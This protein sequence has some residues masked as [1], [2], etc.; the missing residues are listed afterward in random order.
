MTN[1]TSLIE[2]SGGAGTEKRNTQKES[3]GDDDR[4]GE[5]V[6]S[7]LDG[8]HLEL[9][10]ALLS[11]IT[12]KSPVNKRDEIGK[13]CVR[14]YIRKNNTLEKKEKTA[15]CCVEHLLQVNGGNYD[16]LAAKLERVSGWCEVV[17]GRATSQ[18]GSWTKAAEFIHG[19]G[20]VGKDT[21]LIR[22]NLAY[23]G[24]ERDT[25]SSGEDSWMCLYSMWGIIRHMN[26]KKKDFQGTAMSDAKEFAV[27]YLHKLVEKIAVDRTKS[28]S[29]HFMMIYGNELVRG[30]GLEGL[31]DDFRS[32]VS[33]RMD[34]WAEKNGHAKKKWWYYYNNKL[35][36]TILVCCPF[37]GKSKH[38]HARTLH[39][40]QFV[41][42]FGNDL[43]VAARPKLV[44]LR[45]DLVQL[46]MK[47]FTYG[48]LEGRWYPNNFNSVD[49]TDHLLKYIGTTGG[50]LKGLCS[51]M[52]HSDSK[53][54]IPVLH[55]ASTKEGIEDMKRT[56]VC[57]RYLQ[58]LFETAIE[59]DGRYN[60]MTGEIEGSED[61]VQ[62]LDKEWEAKVAKDGGAPDYAWIT[63]NFG[64]RS[65]DKYTCDI[66][67]LFTKANHT[68]QSMHVDYLRRKWQK[69]NWISFMPISE[70]GMYV[71]I[72]GGRPTKECVVGEGNTDNRQ[73]GSVIFI[74]C[75]MTLIV[76]GDTVHG[77]GMHCD[78]YKNLYGNPRL[79]IYIKTSNGH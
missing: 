63:E 14:L 24:Q 40:R 68:T 65:D 64:N 44:K 42:S 17:Q 69:D 61:Y 11:T 41:N 36:H 43:T 21:K 52:P 78:S 62:A 73:E 57:D 8:N 13:H 15:C 79:H 18:R 22:I 30:R 55:Y 33:Q 75:G 48:V 71:Q 5:A 1:G 4:D 34:T 70:T 38:V 66:G 76:H 26:W 10:N 12:I 60:E 35:L 50:L 67:Y 3:D 53:R 77:G 47:W 37:G 39:I 59:N 29:R 46:L 6:L 25:W 20:Y 54:F 19:C 16:L 49:F 51:V 74:P 2:Q 31:N 27:P 56:A 45:P 9:K 23:A 72:W 32:V 28:I 7:N 58:W